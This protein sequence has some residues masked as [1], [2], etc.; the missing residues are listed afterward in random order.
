MLDTSTFI[1]AF[2]AIFPIVN[3]LGMSAIFYEMTKSATPKEQRKLARQVAINAFFLLIAVLFI[4]NY[5]LKF[6]G[7]S[8]PV[9]QIAGGLVVFHSA[10]E[11]LN[12]TEKVSPDT[13]VGNAIFFPLT[14]PITIGTGTI[15]MTISLGSGIGYLDSF[16]NLFQYLSV[17]IAIICVCLLVWI[18]YFFSGWVFQKIGVIGANVVTK[19][20][21]FILL[22][23]GTGI[24]WEGIQGLLHLHS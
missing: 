10:W 6:F 13:E 8:I 16:S 24:T 18:C 1:H 20:S 2:I 11:M 17:S 4:G 5:L 3:P 9:V 12:A 7:L 21:A 23:V 15:A 19:L 22:A 14:M